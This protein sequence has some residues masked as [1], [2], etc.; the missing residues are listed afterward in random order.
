D[1]GWHRALAVDEQLVPALDQIVRHRPA[2][3]AEPDKTDLHD[4]SPPWGSRLT[5]QC[6]SCGGDLKPDG[7]T[8]AVVAEPCPARGVD[9]HG[10]RATGG[11]AGRQPRGA[12][13]HADPLAAARHFRHA[14]PAAG[15]GLPS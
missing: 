4:P 2:H 12:L 3:D 6:Y 5:A 9:R 8:H 15:A 1:L 10:E 7:G 11:G 14:L 13:A